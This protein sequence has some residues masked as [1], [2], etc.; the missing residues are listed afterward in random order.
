MAVTVNWYDHVSE[1]LGDG[2]LDMDTHTFKI[3][4]LNSTHTFNAAHTQ[5][6]EI[7]ANQLATGN[8]YT[9]DNKALA[10]VTWTQTSGTSTFDAADVQWTASG[11]AIGP[12]RHAVIYDDTATNDEIVCN[13]NF[14]ADKT[15][16]DGTTFN[17]NFNASGIF[18]IALP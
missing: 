5:L 10:S 15:A 8:G 6:S 1:I 14:G 4:L 11:G 12:A 2:T 9:Q 17:I 18:T 7:T 3:I 16:D 13:I